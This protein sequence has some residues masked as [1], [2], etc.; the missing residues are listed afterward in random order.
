VPAQ[1]ANASIV[2]RF[3]FVCLLIAFSLQADPAAVFPLDQVIKG[4]LSAALTSKEVGGN[5]RKLV[6][7]YQFVSSKDPGNPSTWEIELRA[8]PV[9]DYE[10]DLHAA[11]DGIAPQ[12]ICIE[13]AS[14]EDRVS[15][16]ESTGGVGDEQSIAKW[17][18]DGKPAKLFIRVLPITNQ[19]ATLAVRSLAFRLQANWPPPAPDRK[20]QRATLAQ[21][22]V[23]NAYSLSIND[24][25][26][27]GP[28]GNQNAPETPTQRVTINVGAASRDQPS[29]VRPWRGYFDPGPISAALSQI[30]EA[31][32]IIVDFAVE[33]LPTWLTP[34]EACDLHPDFRRYLKETLTACCRELGAHPKATQI[35]AATIRLSPNNLPNP[36]RH[37]H[38]RYLAAFRQWLASHYESPASFKEAWQAPDADWLSAEPLPPSSW[39]RGTIGNWLHPA[40]A[41]LL[42]SRRFYNL[43]WLD[44]LQFAV[45]TVATELPGIAIGISDG[46]MLA[47]TRHPEADELAAFALPMLL[48]SEHLH[49]LSAPIPPDLI[50]IITPFLARHN[51]ALIVPIDEDRGGYRQILAT[52]FAGALPAFTGAPPPGWSSLKTLYPELRRPPMPTPVKLPSLSLALPLDFADHRASGLPDQWQ[53]EAVDLLAHINRLGL[54]VTP[55]PGD[56][57]VSA[58]TVHAFDRSKAANDPS[59]VS[60][61][62][63]GGALADASRKVVQP[64]SL[65]P[66]VT[67]R[68]APGSTPGSWTPTPELYEA[69]GQRRSIPYTGSPPGYPAVAQ[70]PKVRIAGDDL[71]IYGRYRDD[72][73]ALAVLARDGRHHLISNSPIVPPVV[74]QHVYKEAKVIPVIDTADQ[75]F[76]RGNRL[77]LFT[78]DTTAS[79]TLSFPAEV[80]IHARL[81]DHRVGA[82]K[83]HVLQLDPNETYIFELAKP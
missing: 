54:P 46:P 31:K 62:L 27:V 51:K 35:V 6:S 79:R 11:E 8:L 14:G 25:L 65:H 76:L 13:I 60:I 53:R 33:S 18:N 41:D 70:S 32:T 2:A 72:T 38:V 43:S 7:G 75:L 58:V 67:L 28:I 21:D 57:R 81:R 39:R 68:L 69:L 40:Q 80:A 71:T 48:K 44:T 59:P 4:R 29:P 77:M 24:R 50:P 36:Q 23:R 47:F 34:E 61:A 3:R 63:T 19:P 16:L 5:A 83:I 74:V 17:R 15:L 26:L 49:F 56:S 30:P 66:D 64:A 42:D 12:V 45:K 52:T 78:D 37:E 55:V 9:G 22:S 20:W 10:I 73:I 1:P 82:S